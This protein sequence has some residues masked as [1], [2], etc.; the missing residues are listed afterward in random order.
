MG[1]MGRDQIS[2]YWIRGQEFLVIQELKKHS[3][4]SAHHLLFSTLA[5]LLADWY[6]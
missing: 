4:K 6:I 3:I 2:D 1:N 5:F